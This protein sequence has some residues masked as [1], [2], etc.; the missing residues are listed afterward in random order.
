MI[1][2]HQASAGQRSEPTGC[3]DG[4]T[5]GSLFGYGF[6]PG[7]VSLVTWTAAASITTYRSR[8]TVSA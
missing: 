1:P 4:T 8:A 5:D 7:P 6:L 3:L 2:P